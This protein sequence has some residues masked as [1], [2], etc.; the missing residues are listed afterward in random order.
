MNVTRARAAT[1]ERNDRGRDFVAGD[2]HG[3]YETLE[4]ALEEVRFE[5]GRDRLFSAG[6]LVNRGPHS[7]DALGWLEGRRIHDAV[8]GNHEA[9]VLRT[10]LNRE[11]RVLLGWMAGIDASLRERW[12]EALWRLPVAMTVATAHGPVGIVHA[13]VV[14]RSW[15][16]TLEGLGRRDRYVISTAL[17]GGYGADWRGR[18]GTP[19]EGL[20]A[21]VTGHEPS[22]EPTCD[23]YWWS[24]DTGA[25][26]RR[27][28]RL[29]L[30]RVD[31]EPMQPH[32]VEVVTSERLAPRRGGPSSQHTAER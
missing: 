23:G 8:L 13:G 4:R 15:S 2:I 3:C 26:V 12:I 21:L 6:D 31:C 5:P 14:D 1:H 10:L 11:R 9:M 17:L 27:F 29:T 7:L 20:R 30:L 28:E 22:R 18:C 32:T 19:V 25:G 16:R 24:I